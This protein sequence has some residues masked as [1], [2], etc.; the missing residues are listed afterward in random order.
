MSGEAY[1]LGADDLKQEGTYI[2]AETGE[3]LAYSRWNGEQPNN[4]IGGTEHCLEMRRE[5]NYTWNDLSC[6]SNISFICENPW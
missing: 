5:Y 2:W 6:D 3:T 1:W 4:L